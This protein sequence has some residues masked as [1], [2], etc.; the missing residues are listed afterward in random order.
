MS[1]LEI[2]GL[3]K[4]F[5]SGD[6]ETRVFSGL[7]L[8]V[9]EGEMISLMG[10]SGSGKTTLLNMIGSIDS[11]DSGSIIVNGR[12]ITKLTDAEA[13]RYRREEI[14]FI[15]QFYNLIP[16][17]TAL[18]NVELALEAI[19]VDRAESERR[20]RSYLERVGLGDRTDRFP[21]ELSGGEQQRVAIARA[22]AKE[23]RIVLADEPTGNLDEELTIEIVELMRRTRDELGVT[24]IIVTHDVSL[25][26]MMDR[27]VDLAHMKGA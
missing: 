8:D 5:R 21:H 7:R 20:S 18:E 14:G 24:Y 10:P 1:V 13:N 23:P 4:S 25:G 26:R 22:L 27:I 3:E 9:E 2:K 16:T 6:V 12:D 19:G 15:F 11:P 17:L